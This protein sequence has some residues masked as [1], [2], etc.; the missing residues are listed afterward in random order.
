[1]DLPSNCAL[2]GADFHVFKQL[3]QSLKA[4]DGHSLA[5]VKLSHFRDKLGG[6]WYTC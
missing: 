1:M 6:T 5:D 4:G 2:T 3:G